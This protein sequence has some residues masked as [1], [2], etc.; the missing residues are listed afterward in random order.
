MNASVLTSWNKELHKACEHP[1]DVDMILFVL[2]TEVVR[3]VIDEA[4]SAQFCTGTTGSAG[5]KYEFVRT[6][7]VLQAF[8]S[9]SSLF[10]L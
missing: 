5:N 9:G 2:F 3:R 7:Q 8:N 6:Q 4:V 1:C 10:S